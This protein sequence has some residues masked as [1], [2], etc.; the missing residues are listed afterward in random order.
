MCDIADSVLDSF[1]W[2]AG[3]N[4]ATW[5]GHG[6]TVGARREIGG[7]GQDTKREQASAGHSYTRKGRTR[8]VNKKREC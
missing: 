6:T 2:C 3:N 5:G 4:G 7:T 1:L 8:L